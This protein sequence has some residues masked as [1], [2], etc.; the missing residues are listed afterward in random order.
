MHP[1]LR[2]SAV[3]FGA[4]F[5]IS[6]PMPYNWWF[7][8]R[9]RESFGMLEKIQRRGQATRIVLAIII[10]ALALSMLITLLPGSISAPSAAPDV[11]AEVDGEAITATE[12][13]RQMSQINNGRPLPPQ[14]EHLYARQFLDN[15]ILERLLEVEARRQGIEVTKQE[16]V[17][18]IRMIIPAAKSG[19][20]QQYATEVQQ[21][22]QMSVPEFEN[23][24]RKM[25]LSEKFA[26][27]ITDGIT[28]APHEVTDHFRRLNEKI[29]VEYALIKP[30]DLEAKVTF[31]EAELAAHYEK[32]KASYQIPERR[33]IRYALL[34]AAPLRGQVKV[35]EDELR[36]YY[37]ENIEQYR[38]ENRARVSHILLKTVGK[39]DAEVEE[40]RKKAADLAKQARGKAKFEDLAK[41]HSEDGSKDKGGDLGWIVP[42]QTVADFEKAAFTLPLKTISDPVKTEYGFHII[43]VDA[44]EAARTQPFEEVRATI[45]PIVASRKAERA[46]SD[47]ADKLGAAIRQNT[48]VSLEDLAKQFQMT[49]GETAP[50]EVNG[51]YGVLGASSALDDAAFR[52]RPG[53]LSAPIQ[54]PQGY[55]VLSLLKTE[56]AHQGSLQEVRSRV[57]S[58]LRREKSQDLAKQHAE[59]LAAR[60]KS[61]SLAA[62]AKAMGITTKTSEPFAR[63]GSLPDIGS[64]KP[65]AP[66]FSMNV[67]DVGPAT[68]LGV[69]WTVYRVASKPALQANQV[70]QQMREAEQSLLQSK[71]QLAFESFT[72]ALR[73]RLIREG[74]VRFNEENLLRLTSPRQL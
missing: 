47:A 28:V 21:R 9:S 30:D 14:I 48:R 20:L 27:V 63:G 59:Q 10:G 5:A 62:A 65:L 67:G 3:A 73:E 41:R 6:N 40:T 35:S 74:V 26:Q 38:T 34:D 15:M 7:P 13:R 4:C 32:S 36:A 43:R 50:T 58:D 18:R 19:D 16:H 25:L 17:D 64:A 53:E 52:L 1:I 61:G 44:R 11:V 60:A 49:I 23:A 24:V 68:S 54:I 42:G 57:E 45:E 39:P 31:T 69:N 29:T 56:P 71:R 22:S 12:V 33:A 55:A 8:N 66:A 51:V 37:N 72:E 70:A 2:S 46:V